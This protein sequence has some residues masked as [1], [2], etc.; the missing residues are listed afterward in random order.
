M[1]T[2]HERKQQDR[3]ARRRRIQEAARQ[4]FVEKG[5]A[6]TSIEQVARRATLSVGA[7]YLYFRSKEDLYVSLLEPTFEAFERDLA[8]AGAQDGLDAV[9]S[10]LLSWAADDVEG[11][12]MLRLTAQPGIRKQLSDDVA[13]AV[14]SGITVVRAHISAQV[15]RGVDDGRYRPVDADLTAD[16]LWS[17][18]LGTLQM[19]DTRA[20]LDLPTTDFVELAR[21]ALATFENGLRATV[22]RVKEAA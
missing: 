11:T 3:K 9:W 1:I 5:Y 19:L 22:A 15:R 2:V 14:A 13:S 16:V 4:V 20:N 10:H 7:I 21:G 6:K 12:R 8:S 17:I 18:F